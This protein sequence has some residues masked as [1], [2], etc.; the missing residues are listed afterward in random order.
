MR[1]PQWCRLASATIV[2]EHLR[3]TTT[4]ISTTTTAAM[5]LPPGCGKGA[6][7]GEFDVS[8][9]GRE[10]VAARS[11]EKSTEKKKKTAVGSN[12]VTAFVVRV[13]VPF[14]V[15]DAPSCS[16]TVRQWVGSSHT[17]TR[18]DIPPPKKHGRLPLSA[19]HRDRSSK[20]STRAAACP[21]LPTAFA[22]TASPMA[23]RIAL[24][25]RGSSSE[26][27]TLQNADAA[28]ALGA[29]LSCAVDLFPPSGSQ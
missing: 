4:T 23:L 14:L 10:R 24:A 12:Q 15:E 17:K 26:T 7:H 25:A 1:R 20:T 16:H 21:P 8:R 13:R 19:P 28:A 9:D 22:P 3:P 6:V 18:L 27:I 11:G 5:I 29:V 2:E